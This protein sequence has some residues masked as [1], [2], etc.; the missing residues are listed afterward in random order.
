MESKEKSVSPVRSFYL[1]ASVQFFPLIRIVVICVLRALFSLAFSLSI[2]AHAIRQYHYFPFAISAAGL[3]GFWCRSWLR[4]IELFI[5][6]LAPRRNSRDYSYNEP[7]KRHSQRTLLEICVWN[8][9]Y[10]SYHWYCGVQISSKL[11]S[12]IEEWWPSSQLDL[13]CNIETTNTSTYIVTRLRINQ[14]FW[15]KCKG[16]L[17]VLAYI[18]RH[19]DWL[20]GMARFRATQT[21]SQ[22]PA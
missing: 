5:W 13:V 21:I 22:I 10:L 6:T 19:L 16:A 1:I 4:K 2:F 7:E 20:W 3:Y 14:H 15:P 18:N 11:H 8:A 17:A 12:F 9:N